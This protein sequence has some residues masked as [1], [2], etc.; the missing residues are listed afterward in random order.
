MEN[1]YTKELNL[2]IEEAQQPRAGKK[3][4]FYVVVLIVACFLTWY[5]TNAYYK[6]QENEAFDYGAM[7][8]VITD[9]EALNKLVEYISALKAYYYFN[10]TDAQIVEGALYGIANIL[11]DPY[12]TYFSKEEIDEY[13]GEMDGSYVGIG[14]SV[15]MSEDG[16]VTILQV[17]P[18][19]PAEAAGMMKGDVFLKVGDVDVTSGYDTNEIVTLIKGEAGSTVN[20]TF[21]RPSTEETFVKD[22]VRAQITNYNVTYKM[23][24]DGVG[25]ISIGSFDATVDSLFEEAMDEL[26]KQG[27]KGIIID[28]RDNGGGYLQQTLNMCNTLV[29]KN[30]LL[31]TLKYADKYGNSPRDEVYRS[32]SNP[33]YKDVELVILVN[34]YSASASEVFTG[35]MKD[36]GRAKIVGETTFGKGIVQSLYNFADGASLKLT[37]A[38]YFTPG[39]Y[40]IHGNGITP[41]IVEPID[42]KYELYSPAVIPEGCDNQLNKAIDTLKD[43]INE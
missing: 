38:S 7:G 6:A 31:L 34:E 3:K 2:K 19:G 39:G 9:E 12:T 29:P 26:Q 42:P 27:A 1:E 25:Y 17:F 37:T 30:S 20:I 22:M 32:W 24:E 36:Y 18:D 10:T 40:E 23:L 13:Y 33:K 14:V 8:E 5:F 41:D 15:S 11:E 28:L 21:Y 4:I 16:L 35:I 43:M